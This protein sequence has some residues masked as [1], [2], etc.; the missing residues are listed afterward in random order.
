MARAAYGDASRGMK[1]DYV[2]CIQ[3]RDA[4]EKL[5]LSRRT[6]IGAASIQAAQT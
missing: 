6:V 5:L 4:Q 2:L 3:L 1:F